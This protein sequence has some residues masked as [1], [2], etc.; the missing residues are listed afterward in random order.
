MTKKKTNHY[1]YKCGLRWQSNF[2]PKECPQCKSRFWNKP[3]YHYKGAMSPMPVIYIICIIALM[4]ATIFYL[5]SA[6]S[7]NPEDQVTIVGKLLGFQENNTYNNFYD[8]RIGN[9]TYLF[10]DFEENYMSQMIGNN[11]NLT[12]CE[13]LKDYYPKKYYNFISAFIQEQGGKNV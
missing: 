3:T 7:C 13:I 4:G 5:S 11:I 2:K 6:P 9:K 8:V 10:K 1:C 12:A